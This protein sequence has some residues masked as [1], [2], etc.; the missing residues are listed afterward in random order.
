M[1]SCELA[2]SGS[3]SFNI[4]IPSDFT[5]YEASWSHQSDS[6]VKYG[7]PINSLLS[8]DVFHTVELIKVAEYYTTNYFKIDGETIDTIRSSSSGYGAIVLLYLE[9]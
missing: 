5:L 7:G 2:P 8:P 6:E 9:P 1:H 3:D 4:K